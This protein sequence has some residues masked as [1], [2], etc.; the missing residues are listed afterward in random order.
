MESVGGGA[1]P[2]G[3]GVFAGNGKWYAI[4]AVVAVGVILYLRSK[5]SA[6][7]S[8]TTGTSATTAPS[9]DAQNQLN[10][11]SDAVTGISSSL[12]NAGILGSGTGLATSTSTS[13]STSN[14]GA[15]QPAAAITGFAATAYP[16]V[17][18]RPVES[19]SV[20]DFWSTQGNVTQQFLG[21]SGSSEGL[22]HAES[23]PSSQ[24]VGTQYAAFGLTP[25]SAGAAYWQGQLTKDIASAGSTNA[26]YQQEQ[27]QFA[28][29]AAQ[30]PN[31][32]NYNMPVKK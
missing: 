18:G 30:N 4:G 3:G 14:A 25:D 29:A 12:G 19:Q 20:A 24:Y 22:S 32:K 8:S 11:L 16:N 17:L 31:S 7:S 2:G 21:I 1:K 23:L 10:A 6:G 9:T 13:T 27:A 15:T 26:G 28:N 5:S